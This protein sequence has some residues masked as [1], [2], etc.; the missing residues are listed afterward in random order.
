LEVTIDSGNDS[1]S[2]H[3]IVS[4]LYEAL[5]STPNPLV[6]ETPGETSDSL[7]VLRNEK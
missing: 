4:V 2:I 1:I 7:F 6:L 5:E 3:H